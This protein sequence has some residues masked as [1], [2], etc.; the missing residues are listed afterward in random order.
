MATKTKTKPTGSL[1]SKTPN[2]FE[3]AYKELWDL[4]PQWKKVA[5]AEENST[6]RCTSLH[7]QFL[8][9]VNLKAEEIYQRA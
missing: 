4:L 9:E 5:F 3:L 6:G 2:P 1:N 7:S 8:E